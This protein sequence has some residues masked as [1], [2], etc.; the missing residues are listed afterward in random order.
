MHG[1]GI[2]TTF[3]CFSLVCAVRSVPVPVLARMCAYRRAQILSLASVVESQWK[4]FRNATKNGGTNFPKGVSAGTL[5]VIRACICACMH[6]HS[7]LLPT[8]V[9][10]RVRVGT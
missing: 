5:F 10:R 4:N 8:I 7:A 6:V 9:P 2:E 1:G 3:L